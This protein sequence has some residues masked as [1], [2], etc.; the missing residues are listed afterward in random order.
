[1]TYAVRVLFAD[2][3]GLCQSRVLSNLGSSPET[4]SFGPGSCQSTRL[5]YTQQRLTFWQTTDS[6]K[7]KG[8]DHSPGPSGSEPSPS[9]D[10]AVA[11]GVPSRFVEAPPRPLFFHES[12]IS[13][14]SLCSSLPS[15]PVTDRNNRIHW[16]ICRTHRWGVAQSSKITSAVFGIA[17][18]VSN[19][20]TR[21][22]NSS[23]GCES[24]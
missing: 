19:G 16:H 5:Y 22:A 23:E 2:I 8:S 15:F 17:A 7:P 11:E 6:G 21:L 3:A 14:I 18:G 10:A 20:A 4:P 1:M 12:I 24:R 9:P 13:S